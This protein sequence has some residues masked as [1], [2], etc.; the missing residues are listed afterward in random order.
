MG[1][2]GRAIIGAV[3]AFSVGLT[4]LRAQ[5]P[6]R[7]RAEPYPCLNQWE[8][9]ALVESGSVQRLVAILFSVRTH[10]PG[11]LVRARLCRRPEGLAYVLTV[12]AYDGKVTKVIIDAVKG[13]L[14]SGR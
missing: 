12:L 3:L 14:I 1:V 11:M 8:R 10:A 2:A 5:E 4:P 6:F 7:P 13:T 9:R